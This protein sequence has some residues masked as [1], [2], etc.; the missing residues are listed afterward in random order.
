[1]QATLGS[2]ELRGKGRQSGVGC[3]LKANAAIEK[4]AYARLT[5]ATGAAAAASA[6]SSTRRTPLVDASEFCRNCNQN[7]VDKLRLEEVWWPL[8]RRMESEKL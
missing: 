4:A 1:V 2:E 8:V 7:A 6:S 5:A 3:M